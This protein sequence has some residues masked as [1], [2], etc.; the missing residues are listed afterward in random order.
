MKTSLYEERSEEMKLCRALSTLL[1]AGLVS[2]T[3]SSKLC[4]QEKLT[5]D[6]SANWTFIGG[7]WTQD[8]E[9]VIDPSTQRADDHLAFHTGKVYKDLEAEFDFR[10]NTNTAGAG[11]IVRAKSP[12]EYYMVYIPQCG[13]QVRA[14]HFW[15]AIAKADG[16]GW[17][18]ML[19]WQMV[20][21][22]P[23]D[24][25]DEGV[26][27][28]WHHAE[29]TVK[30]RRISVSVNGRP[31]VVAEDGDYKSGY[32]G[33][34]S[35]GYTTNPGSSFRNMTVR[36]KAV[37][38]PAFKPSALPP[39]N[40]FIPYKGATQAH[41]GITRSPDGNLLMG[42]DA[43]LLRSLDDGRTWQRVK[44]S[45]WPVGGWILTTRDKRLITVTFKDNQLSLSDSADNGTTWS[46][47]TVV[48]GFSPP[49]D[50]TYTGP[51]EAKASIHASLNPLMELADGTLVMQL[52]GAHPLALAEGH[53]HIYHWGSV[54]CMAFSTRSID[55]GKTWSNL[56]HLSGYPSYGRNL[57]LTEAY[58]TQLKSGEILT[59][60]RPVYSPWMWECRSN[61]GGKSWGASTRGPLPGYACTML[62]HETASGAILIGGRLPGL[63]LNCSFD[64]GMSWQTWQVDRSSWAMGTMFEV[65]PDLVLWV[66]MDNW[67]GDARAQ[68]LRVTPTG[69]VPWSGTER[70]HDR[71]P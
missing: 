4:S 37:K 9:G 45:N 29:V 65:K 35:W 67:G 30:G 48:A 1:L 22:V 25:L 10:M 28:W 33:L 47:P 56:S 24:T 6:G 52:Y 20:H 12:S 54:H 62:S 69:L 39:T 49:Y 51:D 19:K 55:G 5:I 17:L 58:Q 38:G 14:R 40:Y 16:S 71:T 11:F 46:L 63:A 8:A 70:Q 18:R 60:T 64:A 23:S 57:D 68:F 44:D 3:V 61:D 53:S 43:G 66:Y 59:L 21:G 13:Q 7:E 32:L 26:G 15:V 42:T 36:G 27:S 41:G 31:P 34:E 50:H 2:F